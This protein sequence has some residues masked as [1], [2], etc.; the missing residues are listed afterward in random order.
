MNLSYVPYPQQFPYCDEK[1]AISVSCLDLY[2]AVTFKDTKAFKDEKKDK[3]A[4]VVLQ[5]LDEE[6][7]DCGSEEGWLLSKSLCLSLSTKLIY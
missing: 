5:N 6:D 3:T 7:S 4:P 1:T 2:Y